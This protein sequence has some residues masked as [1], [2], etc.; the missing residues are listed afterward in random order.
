[1]T[2]FTVVETSAGTAV[3]TDLMTQAGN[4]LI[5]LDSRPRIV[6]R[7]GIT[8]SAVLRDAYVDLYYGFKFIA[9]L[10][11]T[12]IG[13]TNPLE[14]RDMMPLVTGDALRGGE[15]LRLIVG[16]VSVTNAFVIVLEIVEL[17]V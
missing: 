3:G 8:G 5:A 12:T 17:G 10:Y 7:V 11:P 14:A 16:K 13:V 9:R 2:N 15:L 1:M 6:K 4:N